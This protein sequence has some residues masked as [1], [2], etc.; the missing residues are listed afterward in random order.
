MPA[1]IIVPTTIAVAVQNPKGR[2][3]SLMCRTFPSKSDL[4]LGNLRLSARQGGIRGFIGIRPV[5]I[6]QAVKARP[7]LASF[8]ESQQPKNANFLRLTNKS[9]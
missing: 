7:V 6:G 1:P 4:I 8:I 5:I 2:G 3:A 9:A